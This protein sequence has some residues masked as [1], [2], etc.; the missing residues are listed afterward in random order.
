VKPP[1][2]RRS[3]V[4]VFFAFSFFAAA[5]GA[6]S[7]RV[8]LDSRLELAGAV[9]WLAAAKST[10]TPDA[11]AGS[12]YVRELTGRLP[13]PS[14]PDLLAP[15]PQWTSADR[16]RLMLSLSPVPKLERL[17]A[18]E[19]AEVERA[20]GAEPLERWLAALREFAAA[21]KFGAAFDASR[22]LLDSDAERLRRKLTA[23]S[24]LKALESYTGLAQPGRTLLLLSPFEASGPAPGYAKFLEDGS[25]ALTV[26]IG[27]KASTSAP[28]G[29]EFW[30]D[31]LPAALWNEL[32]QNQLQPLAALYADRIAQSSKLA[33]GPDAGCA[34]DW[35][36]CVEDRIARAV[37]LRLVA[38]RYGAAA[39]TEH[40]EGFD[41]DAPSPLL[42][43]LLA[44]LERYEMSWR[45]AKGAKPVP[46]GA[47]L[48]D[49]YPKLLSSLP[50][51][52]AAATPAPPRLPPASSLSPSQRRRI[53][54]FL[55]SVAPATRDRRLRA[56]A[57]AAGAWARE[58]PRPASENAV[59]SPPEISTAAAA[60]A[61]SASDELRRQGIEK[62]GAGQAE[63]AL[64]DFRAALSSAP[65][66]AQTLASEGAILTTLGRDDE[67]LA[68]Y[69][70]ALGSAR[71]V[72]D[73]PSLLLAADVLSSRA[74]IL[75]RRGLAADAASD[76]E[77]ALRTAPSDWPRG[78]ESRRRLKL[79]KARV[80][81]GH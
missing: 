46:A 37:T 47:G 3:A 15:R 73:S 71:S 14:A 10:S 33:T 31:R 41:G 53:A 59:A 75:E 22:Y 9:D 57:S 12:A 25:L 16:A 1:T 80:R 30:S 36:R 65:H 17:D 32:A 43:A 66:D 13:A 21:S 38:K 8:D 56:L 5:A 18:L 45:R 27:P 20:G 52:D 26:V 39:A 81:R 48:S 50:L 76:L 64:A 49:F 77:D 68:A 55:K 44:G 60:T 6:E 54:G 40:R 35:R 63:A 74:A 58:A 23:A 62:F 42:T 4:L 2:F 11:L 61:A 70:S 7:L 69:A 24:P 72:G 28:S 78:D 51:D 67:A 34:G 29:L 79:L 19:F